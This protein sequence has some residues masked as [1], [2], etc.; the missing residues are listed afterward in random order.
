MKKGKSGEM[1]RIRDLL[2]KAVRV[3]ILG[4]LAGQSEPRTKREMG[5]ALALSNAAVH[6]HV[7]LLEE[8]G[9][10]RFEGTRPGPNSITEKLYSAKPVT[11]NK[12]EGMSNQEKSEFYLR[13]AFDSIR[14]M[15][16]EAEELI[17]SDWR[18]N[19]FLAGCYETYANESE[20]RR[21]KKQI[22]RLVQNF[23]K[24]HKKARK[25]TKPLAITLGL[26][27]SNAAGWGH[28]PREFDM[29]S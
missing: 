22:H 9:L 13:Y 29:M 2:K 16:R 25:D 28:T 27:P 1:G 20:I 21:F 14:E 6:Y 24:K 5:K 10:I 12:D 19:P 4:W 26:L 11:L 7:K 17:R 15:H 18:G 23:F 3:R 8:A